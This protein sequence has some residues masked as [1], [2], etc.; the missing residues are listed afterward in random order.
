[1]IPVPCSL[2]VLKARL[3]ARQREMREL[4][5]KLARTHR[6]S[7]RTP[8]SDRLDLIVDQIDQLQKQLQTKGGGS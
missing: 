8:L 2:E 5:V 4:L 3:I 1:M 7:E 6:G